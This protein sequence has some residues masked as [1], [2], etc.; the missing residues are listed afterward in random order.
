MHVKCA[1]AI[2]YGNQGELAGQEDEP[3]DHVVGCLNVVS[4]VVV[5]WTR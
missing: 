5:V 1:R 4:N 2:F 3:L